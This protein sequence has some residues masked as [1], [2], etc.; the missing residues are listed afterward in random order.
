MLNSYIIILLEAIDNY[1]Q[2]IRYST[3]YAGSYNNKGSA[4]CILEQYQEAIENLIWLLSINQIFQRLTIIKGIA[5]NELGRHQEAI[6]SC[7]LAIK[8]DSDNVYAYQLANEFTK[9]I[10]KSNL[11]IITD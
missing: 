11:R 10:K 2:A 7:N 8:Y 9:K 3:N 5:L 4:L 1:D 6:E